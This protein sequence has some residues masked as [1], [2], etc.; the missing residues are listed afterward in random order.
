MR[1]QQ[2]DFIVDFPLGDPDKC[3]N[4]TLPILFNHLVSVSLAPAA[5]V[6]IQNS[7]NRP[8]GSR[9]DAETRRRR[10]ADIQEYLFHKHYFLHSSHSQLSGHDL[11]TGA[12]NCS[13]I[14]TVA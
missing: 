5:L 11:G 9:S 4:R 10:D 6:E 2:K 8:G 13:F 1:L 14:P 12:I 3:Q 7:G